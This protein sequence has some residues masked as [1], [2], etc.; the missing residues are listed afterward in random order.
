[1]DLTEWCRVVSHFLEPGGIFYITEKHP[2]L[3]VFDDEV[4]QP[5]LR[6]RYPYWT[7]EKPL[8]FENIGSYAD[9]DAPVTVPYEY[10]WDHSLGEVVTAIAQAGLRVEF[11]HEFD[12]I[13]W[14]MPLVE[15]DHDGL[16]RLPR[17]RYGGRE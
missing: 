9:R 7:K 6:L 15:Q 17:G 13:E 14:P 8:R 2:V 12:F 5:V 3:D 1:P 11:L 16:W 4:S 10:G